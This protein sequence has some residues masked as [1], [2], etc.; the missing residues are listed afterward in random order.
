MTK[1]FYLQDKNFRSMEPYE[2][3]KSIEELKRGNT[4][5]ENF[6]MLYV[7]CS[8]SSNAQ[9]FIMEHLPI[10]FFEEH[11]KTDDAV[12]IKVINL[13]NNLSVANPNNQEKLLDL[14]IPKINTI[15]WNQQSGKS[16]MM[17]LLACCQPTS[18]YRKRLTVDLLLPF[19]LVYHNATEEVD[20]DFYFNLITLMAEPALEFLKYGLTHLDITY[21]ITDLL[22]DT[23]EVVPD[24]IDHE[25][26]IKFILE[27]I[28]QRDLKPSQA[29]SNIIGVFAALVGSSDKARCT[30]LNCDAVE[31]LKKLNKADME[32]PAVLEWSVAA[33]RFLVQFVD[34]EGK[35]KIYTPAPDAENIFDDPNFM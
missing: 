15:Q 10:S 19:V 23:A 20:E 13:C 12:F 17:F 14:L 34:P 27:I 16:F 21:S 31:I 30:A 11:F 7:A 35:N 1:D 6:K 29:R 9:D 18:L 33:L 22:H 3:I 32:D 26:F 2:I 28:Q 5:P 24:Q 4:S 25:P 8:K